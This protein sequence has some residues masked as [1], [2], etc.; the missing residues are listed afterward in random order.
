ESD[1]PFI[2]GVSGHRDLDP[3][4]T[5]RLRAAVSEFFQELRACLPNTEIRV[6]VGMASGADLLVAKAALDL[7]LSIDAVLPL[8]LPRYAADFEAETFRE[9][10]ALLA[11]PKVRCTELSLAAEADSRS[12]SVV[13]AHRDA[14]YLNLTRTLVGTCHLLLA[15]WDGRPSGAPGGTTDTV[16]R[17]LGLR[18][19]GVPHDGPIEFNDA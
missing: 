9:L 16:L 2:V 11:R 1:A 3:G 19:D 4:D 7:G 5:P 17:Y 6:M 10:E 12:G 15:V 18:L 13:D 14:H 8:P